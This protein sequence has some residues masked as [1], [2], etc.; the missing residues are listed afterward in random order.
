MLITKR[1]GKP[2][3][4]D[5]VPLKANKHD[6]DTRSLMP[7]VMDHY[8]ETLAP[9][10]SYKVIFQPKPEIP[11]PN[12]I[13]DSF[14]PETLPEQIPSYPAEYP[15]ARKTSSQSVV[16]SPE[17]QRMKNMHIILSVILIF[18]LLSLGI[19]GYAYHVSKPKID[20]STRVGRIELYS[21]DG[22]FS[23]G[24]RSLYT[25]KSYGSENFVIRIPK[26]QVT[27]KRNGNQLWIRQQPDKTDQ[28]IYVGPMTIIYFNNDIILE[29]WGSNEGNKN[30]IYYEGK[31]HPYHARQS[32]VSQLKRGFQQQKHK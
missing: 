21:P 1:K 14:H 15:V 5:L 6:N 28:L 9:E 7:E 31:V 2:N 11:E 26:Q 20:T 30:Q 23:G 25:I 24:V 22:Q 13:S 10:V 32:T 16:L 3:I 17:D 8:Y 4:Y 19:L 18:L 27:F 29:Q 12:Y